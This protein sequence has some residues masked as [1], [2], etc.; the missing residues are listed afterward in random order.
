M[1]YRALQ[2]GAAG[3]K[4][5]DEIG[6]LLAEME[7]GWHLKI[8]SQVSGGTEALVFLATYK[9]TP[10]VVKLGLPGSLAGE[11]RTLRLGEGVGYA[12]LIDYD[13]DHEALILERLGGQLA[14]VKLSI[15][16]QIEAICA[17][18][19]LA[20]RRIDDS[21]WLVTG[22]EKARAQA[23][24]IRLQWEELDHPCSLQLIDGALDY[25]SQR[26]QAFTL[27]ESCLVHGDAHVWNTLEAVSSPTG[28]KFVDPEGVI[29]EPAIDLAV[30]LRE[31]RDELLES[32]TLDVGQRRCELLSSLSNVDYTAIW[33]WGVIEHVSCGLLDLHL[34]DPQA[35]GQHFT[36]ASRWMDS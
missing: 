24:F 22:A 1:K 6:E 3:E 25:A 17:T 16:Q 20:W 28:Y 7:T 2:L 15:E 8:G 13:A 23:D 4:W 32:D 27:S 30:S 34:N 11:A 33:Q 36:I 31:W 14:E 26:E 18:L 9:N 19:K 21:D 12:R 29:G 5:L 35:A 10:V